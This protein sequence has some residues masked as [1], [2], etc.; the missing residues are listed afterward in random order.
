MCLLNTNAHDLV[1]KP[2]RDVFPK[3]GAVDLFMPVKNPA[4]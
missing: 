3:L 1:K 4:H 2:N